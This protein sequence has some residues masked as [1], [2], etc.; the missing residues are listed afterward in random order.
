MTV[1]SYLLYLGVV[2]AFFATPPDTSQ[3]LVISHSL[4]H[5]LRRSTA[6]IAGDLSANVLQMTAAAFGLAA[7]IAT[8]AEALT[9]VKWLGVAYLAWLG[10]R[11]MLSRGTETAAPASVRAQAARMFRAGFLTSSANPYAV[12]FFGALFPQFI[13]PAQAIWPQLL[14]LGATYLVVDGL[15]LL[16]WGWAAE[17]AMGRLGRISGLWINRVCGGLMVAAAALLAVKD[18]P[19]PEPRT[20]T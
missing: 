9:V 17:R 7:L 2:A 11:L 15:I 20:A 10:L 8:S 6:V 13:D 5:G 19:A 18:L 3:L 12:V 4:R 14:I 16:L 1:E